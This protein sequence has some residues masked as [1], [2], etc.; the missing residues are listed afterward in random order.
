VDFGVCGRG[1]YMLCV[2]IESRK[3]RNDI[4][5]PS[6]SSSSICS[7][8]TRCSLLSCSVLYIRTRRGGLFFHFPFSLP[9]GII[10]GCCW[11]CRVFIY[12]PPSLSL[13]LCYVCCVIIYKLKSRPT[14]PSLIFFFKIKMKLAG[15]NISTVNGLKKTRIFSFLFFPFLFFVSFCSSSF[16]P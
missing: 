10:Y 14:A 9:T 7:C 6:S 15:Q 4:G 12:S 16:F 11:R 8:I 13:S 1:G 3:S 2:I 5:P